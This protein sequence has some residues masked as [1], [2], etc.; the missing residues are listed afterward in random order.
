L[1]ATGYCAFIWKDR[2]APT[3][4]LSKDDANKFLAA[5]IVF[6]ILALI[7]GIMVCCGYNSLKTAIDVVDASADFL[8]KTK[9]ILFVPILYFLLNVLAV[10]AWVVIVACFNSM[11]K[12]TADTEHIPQF[13]K[14]TAANGHQE[15][16]SL[17]L[18]ALFFGLLWV[19]AFNQAVSSFIVMVSATSYYFNSD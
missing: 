11:G 14:S 10:F 7:F 4:P 9:R 12:I 18:C 19:V 5:S 17:I 16:H 15:D 3:G 1:A 13:R 8:A 2:N 6:A